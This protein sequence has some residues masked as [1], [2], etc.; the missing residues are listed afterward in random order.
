MPVAAM[1][2]DDFHDCTLLGLTLDWGAKS[3]VFDLRGPKGA[4]KL[5][6]RGLRQIELTRDDPWGPSA[7]VNKVTVVPSGDDAALRVVI[8]IQS[9][10]EIRLTCAAV[11]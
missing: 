8:E 4:Q 10:D 9:G 5:A 1:A 3:A 6:V 7:S 2:T 11:R